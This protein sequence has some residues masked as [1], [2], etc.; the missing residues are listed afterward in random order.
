MFLELSCQLVVADGQ[1]SWY[2]Q[3]ISG[4]APAVMLIG[5]RSFN[6]TVSFLFAE[7]RDKGTV[8]PT[9]FVEPPMTT[10]YHHDQDDQSLDVWQLDCVMLVSN[11]R[12]SQLHADVQRAVYM[13]SED[14]VTVL[15]L[16]H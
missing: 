11:A 15:P 8:S 4:R 5:D 1:Q 14:L 6:L 9:C 2:I 16:H 12:A 3:C 7:V 10:L 13:I